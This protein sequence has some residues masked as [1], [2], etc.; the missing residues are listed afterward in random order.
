MIKNTPK[1]T[2]YIKAFKY[3]LPSQFKIL[4]I[5]P[6]H[7]MQIMTGV[8]TPDKNT[9][10][11]PSRSDEKIMRTDV[12]SAI[13]GILEMLEELQIEESEREQMA[14]F[15]ANSIFVEENN[16]NL[17]RALSVLNKLE[18]FTSQEEKIYA[19]YKN[20]PPLLALETLTNATMSFISKYTGIKGENTTFGSTSH[21]AYE[22]LEESIYQLEFEQVNNVL[23]GGSN[24][25]GLYS[26]LT[27]SNFYSD[28]KGWKESACASF[29]VLGN[30]GEIKI[31]I[32]RHNF[33]LPQLEA[34]E[35]KRTWKDFFKDITPSFIV[36]SGGY[37]DSVF[38]ENEAE[39]KVICPHYFSWETTYGNL[40]AAAIFMN[41]AYAYEQI[42]KG[43]TDTAD[44]LNRD[45]YGRETH[46]RIEKAKS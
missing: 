21:A 25:S 10:F 30:E 38:K 26:F 41:L 28:T 15:V 9:V 4:E 40:G 29:F 33:A 13:I 34:T 2:I 42:E 17:N 19:I 16:K 1:N 20:T 32:L 39:V 31:S 22:A 44:I 27:Y 45:V 23:V 35:I 24:C 37:T 11:Y 3:K 12:V 18:D 7:N 8:L 46:I 14:L 36:Y 5:S 43:L 6:A